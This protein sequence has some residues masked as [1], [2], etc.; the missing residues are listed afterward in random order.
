M[1]LPLDLR[2]FFSY[3]SAGCGKTLPATRKATTRAE[4]RTILNGLR[5]AEA[6]LFHGSADIGEFFRSLPVQALR[7]KDQRAKI[8]SVMAE[9]SIGRT[10]L[11][12]GDCR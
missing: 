3:T 11:S 12:Q 5:G 7:E 4:A 2:F 6:P 9:F 8:F 10:S 1:Y